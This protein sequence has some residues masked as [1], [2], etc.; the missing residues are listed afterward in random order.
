MNKLLL[1]SAFVLTATVTY[2]QEFE[3]WQFYDPCLLNPDILEIRDEGIDRAIVTYY[4]SES[5]CS[6]DRT[7]VLTSDAGISVE[8]TIETSDAEEHI[9]VIPLEMQLFSYP[10]ESEILDGESQD[11]IIMGGMM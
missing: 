5:L 11:F 4:N 1:A 9:T 8:V 10:P 3:P 2:A 7:V 6:A